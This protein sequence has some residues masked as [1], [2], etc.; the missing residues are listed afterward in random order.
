MFRFQHM[1]SPAWCADSMNSIYFK[2][3]A[4][5]D[6]K[7][8]EIGYIGCQDND[9]GR[10]LCNNFCYKTFEPYR[11]KGLTKA[12][13]K[14]FIENKVLDFDCIRARVP[15]DNIASQKVLEYAGFENRGKREDGK[16]GFTWKAF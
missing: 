6:G 1:K 16:Y 15:R 10:G 12:Y 14:E 13:V 11:E 7:E 4:K 9:L 8:H 5:T 3:F 2:V